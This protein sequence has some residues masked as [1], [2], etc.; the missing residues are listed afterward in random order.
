[1]QKY[2]ITLTGTTPLLMHSDNIEWADKMDSWKTNAA[3]KAK[4]KAGDDRAP[5]YRWIGCL[6]SDGETVVI[7]QDNLMPCLRKAG[8][9]VP[10][11]GGK[12]GKTFKSQTQSGMMLESPALAFEGAAGPIQMSDINALIDVQEFDAHKE[13]ALMLG[14]DLFMKRARIGQSK[15]IR[16]RPRFA[17]WSASG[18]VLVWDEQLTLDALRE[19]LKYA[20]QY[21]GL[22][23]WRPGGPTP[24]PYG[25]FEATIS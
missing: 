21:V 10:V 1:M 19:I 6:Y 20:G 14:F 2:Q 5:A 9:M 22:G 7:P 11:P 4:G 16:V 3:N 25:M 15:H 8:A 13:A 24:G 12:R 18:T 23:D 17:K